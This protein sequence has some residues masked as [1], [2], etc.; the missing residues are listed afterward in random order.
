MLALT[1][2]QKKFVEGI[3]KG[4]NGTQSVLA[5]YDTISVNTAGNIASENLRKPKIR[6]ALIPF[7]NKHNITL[8]TAIAPIGKGL[9]AIKMNEYTGEI[10]EDL[11]TQ[12]K[13][14]D[15]ALK[16]LGVNSDN[17]QLHLHAHIDGQAHKYQI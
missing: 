4:K 16:L 13:A 8:D 6:D 9:R 15:R 12:L 11:Q 5:A 7:L 3:T 1:N 14:S 17:P 2:K 10:T